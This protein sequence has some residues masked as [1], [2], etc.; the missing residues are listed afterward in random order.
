MKLTQFLTAL[1]L[2]ITVVSATAVAQSYAIK[3]QVLY[4]MSGDPILNGVVLVENGKIQ[5][6]GLAS[7]ISIPANAEVLEARVVTPGF[8]DAR[9]VVGLAGA[10]NLP[11]VSDHIERSNPFQPELRAIDAYN[12]REH[13]VVWLSN[14]G[15]TTIHTGHAPGAIASGQTMIAKT[16]G[17]TLNEA[18]VD[19]VTMVAFTLG[20]SVSHNYTQVGSRSRTIAMLR[21]EF[22]K[23]Q[24]YL[25]RVESAG[26]DASKL[27]SRDLKLETMAAVLKGEIKALITAQ[28]VTE[29]LGALRLQ[30]EFGFDL[31]LDGAAEAYLV[32]DEI[33]AA[34]VPV[35]VHPPMVRTRGETR[36]ASWETPAKLHEA[37]IPF[38]FQAGY[39]GYVPKTRVVH[40]E[41]GIAVANGLPYEEGLAALTIV[42]AQLLG[43]D[44]RVGSLE[45]GKDADIAM[46]D[47]DPFEYITHTIGVMIDGKMVYLKE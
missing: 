42:P 17:G 14:L 35:F 5:S 11:H 15:I 24:E 25:A 9:S 16:T 1:F 20:S 7:E 27:P 28:Q 36:N 3:A 22:I 44:H 40:F 12:A 38:A 18:L 33:K 4:T 39:E 23:A 26:G 13:L 43:I 32:L 31:V 29:I 34:G 8:I 45:V 41:A 21:S 2:L 47:G 30:E 10:E 6:V 46:F 19:S 37:G